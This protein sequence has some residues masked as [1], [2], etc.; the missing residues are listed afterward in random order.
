MPSSVKVEDLPAGAYKDV[1]IEAVERG[2]R[3]LHPNPDSPTD[4]RYGSQAV[5]DAGFADI[6]AELRGTKS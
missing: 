4:Q 6:I 2:N 5:I 1:L 3:I